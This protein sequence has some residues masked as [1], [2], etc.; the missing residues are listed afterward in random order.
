EYYAVAS[1]AESP[2]PKA[3]VRKKQSSSD[4]TVP[5]PTKGKRLKILA[6][7]DKPAKEKQPA[8]SSTAKGL[9]VLSEVALT[10]AEQINSS[11]LNSF[12]DE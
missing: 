1:R 2:K 8:K 5:P 12:Q 3:S 10:E 6:K 7:V 9:T 4:T 11:P